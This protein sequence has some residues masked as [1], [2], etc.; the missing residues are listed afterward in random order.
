[1]SFVAELRT[2]SDF[3]TETT[4]GV[5][6]DDLLGPEHPQFRHEFAPGLSRH[7]HFGGKE[8]P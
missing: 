1:M 3:Q 6:R 8:G 7:A 2:F 4:S 5:C